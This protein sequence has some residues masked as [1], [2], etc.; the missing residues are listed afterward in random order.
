MAPETN[1]ATTANPDKPPEG[2][3][4]PSNAAN[5]GEVKEQELIKNIF[6]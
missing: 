4:K 1:P 3:A 6:V 5:G 2:S